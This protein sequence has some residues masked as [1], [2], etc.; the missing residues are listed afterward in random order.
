MQQYLSLGDPH[1]PPHPTTH[2]AGVLRA[3]V[4]DNP[5]QLTNLCTV[6]PAPVAV[7]PPTPFAAPPPPPPHPSYNC[8]LPNRSQSGMTGRHTAASNAAIA[9]SVSAAA[10]TAA[11]AESSWDVLLPCTTPC[12]CECCCSGCCRLVCLG[13]LRRRST[14]PICNMNGN[15]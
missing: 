14:F 6:H 7:C 2:P 1:A 10:T 15:V 4:G 11:A 13:V 3:P 9:A 8:Y 12:C 5:E